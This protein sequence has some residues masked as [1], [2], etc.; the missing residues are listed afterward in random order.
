MKGIKIVSI[1]VSLVLVGVGSASLLENFG[2]ISGT[3][4]VKP[5]VQ[6]REVQYNP[7]DESSQEYLRVVNKADIKVN[8]TDWELKD[9]DST[10]TL[11]SFNQSYST[12]LDPD[13][14]GYI[15][16]S[17]GNADLNVSINKPRIAVDDSIG[18]GGLS[19]SGEVLEL[20]YT[21]GSV[22]SSIDYF[23]ADCST[24]KSYQRSSYRGSWGC[25]TA[26]LGGN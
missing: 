13:Q 2:S 4:D 26:T 7:S 1:M 9:N 8:L 12:V 16:E 20:L 18:D 19:N 24:S 11:S 22:I 17:E 6:I 15:T 3:A 5:S 14:S 21:D 10:D 25:E 23:D